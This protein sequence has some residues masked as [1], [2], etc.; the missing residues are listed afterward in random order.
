MKTINQKPIKINEKKKFSVL[1][2]IC[3]LPSSFLG[4][5]CGNLCLR[6]L[7]RHFCYFYFQAVE[8]DLISFTASATYDFHTAEV[9][10]LSVHPTGTFALCSSCFFLYCLLLSLECLR[11]S[12]YLA[13]ILLIFDEYGY[14]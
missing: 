5:G 4:C 9:T 13:K 10:A 8:A 2:F 1:I 14:L 12:I 7:F 11:K 3:H 6:P